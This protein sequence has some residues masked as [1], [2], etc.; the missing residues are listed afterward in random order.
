MYNHE[1]I[2]WMMNPASQTSTANATQLHKRHAANEKSFSEYHIRC[3]FQRQFLIFKQQWKQNKKKKDND[4]MKQNEW[5]VDHKPDA[6]QEPGMIN[7]LIVARRIIDA[8]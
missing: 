1:T 5:D 2:E 4:E 7:S 3:F 8:Q 6:N